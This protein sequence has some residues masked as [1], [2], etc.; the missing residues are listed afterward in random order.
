MRFLHGEL[1]LAEDIAADVRQF[2]VNGGKYD[3]KALALQ[4]FR[5]WFRQMAHQPLSGGAD[6]V[7]NCMDPKAVLTELAKFLWQNRQLTVTE[8]QE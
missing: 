2:P 8:A 5:V 1:P 3:G 4:V 6:V 7:I